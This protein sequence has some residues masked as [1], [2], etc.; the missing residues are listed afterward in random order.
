MYHT[1][2]ACS[3]TLATFA[4]CLF[5]PRCTSIG[6]PE[7]AECSKLV[8]DAWAA[9]RA[10]LVVASQCKKPSDKLA[11][12][13]SCGVVDACQAAGKAT[14]RGDFENHYKTV[15][16]GLGALNWLMIEPQPREIIEAQV[17]AADY[18]A[19][20]I[21]IAFKRNTDAFN[22]TQHAFCDSFKKLLNDL[23]P[24]TKAHHLTGVTWN[25][26]GGDAAG[27]KAPAAPAVAAAAPKPPAA[28]AAGGGGADLAAEMAKLKDNAAAGLKKVAP[29]VGEMREAR[30]RLF[31]LFTYPQL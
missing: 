17:G 16:E 24:Y 4:T 15:A 6:G 27:F 29:G 7:L 3:L 11:V 21:R 8:A 23:I 1:L 9:Q 5:L 14:K 18:S 19:N 2:I 28:A 30:G 26:K 10:F 22:P 13:K 20:K 25:F 12:M 31:C